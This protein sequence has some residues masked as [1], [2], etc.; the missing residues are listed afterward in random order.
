MVGREEGRGWTVRIYIKGR[1][2]RSFIKSTKGGDS[3]M[4]SGRKSIKGITGDV[5]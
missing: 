3:V 1:N 2:V 5:T 4:A